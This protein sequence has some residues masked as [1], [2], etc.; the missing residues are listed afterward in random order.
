M[1]S[2]RWLGDG[3]A[4]DVANWVLPAQGFVDR[5]SDL[6]T[7]HLCI[8]MK[9]WIDPNPSQPRHLLSLTDASRL[10]KNEAE[11]DRADH[12]SLPVH[13]EPL[14]GSDRPA[15]RA[16]RS[17]TCHE[18]RLPQALAKRAC[19]DRTRGAFHLRRSG[20]LHRVATVEDGPH[21]EARDPG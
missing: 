18:G 6:G 9:R 2:H 13:S 12:G 11:R 21:A 16:P 7:P 10:W 17:T 5:R 3:A 8:R 4:N 20:D 14:G 19:L 1:A 15:S